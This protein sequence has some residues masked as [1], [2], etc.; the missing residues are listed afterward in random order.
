MAAPELWRYQ[1]DLNAPEWGVNT[2][3]NQRGNQDSANQSRA[4]PCWCIPRQES[5][6]RPGR[7]TQKQFCHLQFSTSTWRRQYWLQGIIAGGF[8]SSHASSSGYP[9]SPIAIM[10]SSTSENPRAGIS[11]PALRSQK[12]LSRLPPS[13]QRRRLHRRRG[14]RRD[15]T[16]RRARQY[17]LLTSTP[18]YNG[19]RRTD[20]KFAPDG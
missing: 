6:L 17:R 14:P 1:R 7:L 20:H 2:T 10:A 13:P 5:E 9:P 8:D 11:D 19:R 18:I 16:P 3:C 4:P 15:F 12:K